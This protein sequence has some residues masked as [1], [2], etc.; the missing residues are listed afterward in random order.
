MEKTQVGR[1]GYQCPQCGR[2]G[3][4]EARVLYEGD[5]LVYAQPANAHEVCPDCGSPIR[6]GADQ[7]WARSP[8]TEPVIAPSQWLNGRSAPYFKMSQEG[9]AHQEHIWRWALLDGID[10][11]VTEDSQIVQRRLLLATM[12]YDFFT[13]SPEVGSVLGAEAWQPPEELDEPYTVLVYRRDTGEIVS[14][15]ELPE[16][17]LRKEEVLNF[18]KSFQRR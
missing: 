10:P 8:E 4:V 11:K 7:W 16:D 14:P 5:R 1:C 6:A 15:G 18:V 12:G 13:L 2:Q 9:P 3:F 17:E